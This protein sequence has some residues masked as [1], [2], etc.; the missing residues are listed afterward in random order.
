VLLSTKGGFRF[1]TG[2]NDTGSSRFHLIEAVNSSL[3]RLGTS[4]IDIYQ[5]HAF[6]AHTPVEEVL[7]ALD[8]LVRAGKIRYIGASNFSGWHL[9]KSLAASDRH[10]WS[11]YVCHQALYSLVTREFEW[12]LMPL[13]IDQGV[14]TVVW[15]PLA[16][17]RLTGKIRRGVARP[18]TG[19]L[20]T[21]A[22]DGGPTVDDDYLLNVVDVMAAVGD[23]VGKSVPQVAI[24]WLLRRPTV[25]SVIMGARTEQQL[26][27][28][29]GAVGWELSAEQVKRLD[30]VSTRP[31]TYPTWH[32]QGYERNPNPV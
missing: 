4:H 9:M 27:D 12:E 31:R 18:T 6:D 8:D 24:N 25:S 21:V 3:R 19:R 28:N 22:A 20:Q 30:A 23:E 7:S 32:Q 15:S 10:G 17:G 2:P 5:L 1:G 29:L 26:I 16:W 13:A 14:G 11:R